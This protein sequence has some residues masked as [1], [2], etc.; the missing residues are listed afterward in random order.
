MEQIDEA[1]RANW[2]HA[3]RYVRKAA[4]DLIADLAREHDLLKEPALP[5]ERAT[6]GLGVYAAKP[7]WALATASRL[8]AS[9]TNVLDRG[10]FLPFRRG[11]PL[12]SNRY[13]GEVAARAGSGRPAS[14]L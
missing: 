4:A 10:S 7:A 12:G 13:A 9:A 3:D 8:R 14:P 2:G 5:R 1:V 6:W 11:M